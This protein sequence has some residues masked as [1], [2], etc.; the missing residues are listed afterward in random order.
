MKS[1]SQFPTTRWQMVSQAAGSESDAQAM[2]EL[3]EAY[4]PPL[5]SFIRARGYNKDAAL[6]LVQGYF[7]Q[8]L[9]K[10]YV[11]DYDRQKGRFRTFLLSSLRNYMAKEWHASQAL[12]RGGGWDAIPFEDSI[13]SMEAWYQQQPKSD[14][15]EAVYDRQWAQ[16]VLDQAL[17]H[18]RNEYER[19]NRG[20]AFQVL[21]RFL[22]DV[23]DAGDYA[24]AARHLDI[25]PASMKVTVHRLR[26]RY[27]KCIRDVVQDTVADETQID[28]ELTHLLRCL[29]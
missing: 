14:S 2:R 13:E 17:N 10:D 28:S 8:L 5:H 23:A 21:Q 3:C 27:R 24:I 22:T 26:R 29:E 11:G 4:W 19:E 6:D 1:T 15:P 9:E 16:R 25:Q 7:H 12:K 18:L 20:A